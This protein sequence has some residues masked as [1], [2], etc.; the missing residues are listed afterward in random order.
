MSSLRQPALRSDILWDK[1][2][3][4]WLHCQRCATSSLNTVPPINAGASFLL[5]FSFSPMD[6]AGRSKS[7]IYFFVTSKSKS[8]PVHSSPLCYC[9]IWRLKPESLSLASA[10]YCPARPRVLC[11]CAS[12]LQP[13]PL[14]V[15]DASTASLVCGPAPRQPILL[16]SSW[17]YVKSGLPS[18]A[19]VLCADQLFEK[20]Y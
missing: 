1:K 8:Y 13:S 7:A 10:C 18:R 12:R 17:Y 11:C 6:W 19:M 5:M 14:I 4:D 9:G 20:T 16:A 2:T 15:W 3:V